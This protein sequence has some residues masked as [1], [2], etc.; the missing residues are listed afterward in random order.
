MKALR[1]PDACF[2]NLPGYPFAP[3]Y[4]DVP[5]GEGGT[6]RIHH[7]ETGPA[8]GTPVLCMHGQPTWSYLYRHMLPILGDAGLRAIAPD[9]VG[10]GR[11]D[12]PSRREDFSYNRQ[13]EWMSAWLVSR[14][15]APCERCCVLMAHASSPHSRP[16]SPIRARDLHAYRLSTSCWRNVS[17]H[18]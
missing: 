13:V 17:R 7:V 1:T 8:D 4:T 9:L 11:S 16:R 3:H 15:L 18:M 12:K 2:E 14:D 6:L 10:Y 5:D